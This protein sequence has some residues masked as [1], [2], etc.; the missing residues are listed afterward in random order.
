[1]LVTILIGVAV[2]I[3]LVLVIPI[4]IKKDYTVERE[5]TILKPR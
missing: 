5:I 3:A 4:F 2:L 1:M